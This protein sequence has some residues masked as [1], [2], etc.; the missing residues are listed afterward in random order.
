MMLLSITFHSILQISS[1]LIRAS[2]H[3]TCPGWPTCWEWL[4]S[5]HGWSAWQQLV[6]DPGKIIELVIVQVWVALPDLYTFLFQIAPRPWHLGWWSGDLVIWFTW[7]ATADGYSFFFK[8]FFVANGQ[9]FAGLTIVSCFRI[10]AIQLHF[11]LGGSLFLFFTNK[12]QR[13]FEGLWNTV[14]PCDLNILIYN[15]TWISHQVSLLYASIPLY[16]S[17]LCPWCSWVVE[18]RPI[19]HKL[20]RRVPSWCNLPHS[21]FLQWSALRNSVLNDGLRRNCD[22]GLFGLV[23]YIWLI[24]WTN[25]SMCE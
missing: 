8:M 25:P 1:S 22:I 6:V 19:S 17:C 14:T 15:M 2:G 4:H 9:E 10:V 13:V 23:Y 11:L 16:W 3:I 20:W 12:E 18:P 21:V 7:S 24:W 5:S